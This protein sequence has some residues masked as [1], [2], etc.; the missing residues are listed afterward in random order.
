MQSPQCA[1]RQSK[2]ACGAPVQ[3]LVPE[4]SPKHV[5]AFR[6]FDQDLLGNDDTMGEYDIVLDKK[7]TK[8][9]TQFLRTGEEV[10]L[11]LNMLPKKG[12]QDRQREVPAGDLHILAQFT[13]FFNAAGGDDTDGDGEQDDPGKAMERL[14]VRILPLLLL[15]LHFNAC[16][17]GSSV[18]Q[19]PRVNLVSWIGIS[20]SFAAYYCQRP[21]RM[22]ACMHACMHVGAHFTWCAPTSVCARVQ[23]ARKVRAI[24]D[25]SKGVLTVEIYRC[26]DLPLVGKTCDSFIELKLSD[27]DN[28]D[29]PDT[30]RTGTV[31]NERSPRF[32]YKSDFVYISATSTL[33]LQAPPCQLVVLS[34]NDALLASCRKISRCCNGSL[35]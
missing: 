6:V 31:F 23:Q 33:T 24:D 11:T 29:P 15:K 20:A 3:I 35:A 12:T 30:R 22:H 9:D 32:R 7:S 26:I 10:Q 27:P 2:R 13:P 8:P 19:S 1:P 25:S 14:N 16:Y 5:L 34:T 17:R 18:V 21:V 4:L 28:S